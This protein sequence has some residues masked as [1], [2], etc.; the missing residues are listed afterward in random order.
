MNKRLRKKNA[1]K[2]KNNAIIELTV[3]YLSIKVEADIKRRLLLGDY[4]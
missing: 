1:K 3:E 2:R 4:E